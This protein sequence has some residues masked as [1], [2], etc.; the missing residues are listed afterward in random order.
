[1]GTLERQICNPEMQ[2]TLREYFGAEERDRRVLDLQPSET[3]ITLGRSGECTY[4]I[5]KTLGT[6]ALSISKVQA[7]ITAPDGV[8]LLQ[9]GGVGGVSANG[10][11]CHGER[12]DEPVPLVP[13]L[14]LTL[15]KHGLAKVAFSVNT[16][17]IAEHRGDTYT[18][19]GLVDVLQEQVHAISG[20]VA[21][22]N[23]QIGLLADQLAAR[24]ALDKQQAERDK[25][26]AERDKQQD[27]RLNRVLAGVC[28]VIAVI[29]LLS[30]WSGGSAE[31]KKA[32][33]STFTSVAI[34]IAALYFKSQDHPKP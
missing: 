19:Q 6:S 13:G 15:F 9:D 24:E 31:D 18:G 33:S 7:T 8:L 34:G 23:L 29:V 32:W 22:M 27:Q 3:P 14:E 4:Q 10:I 17:A 30:G 2:A 12:L 21:A 20:Q 11:Y 25:Q 16:T 5:G 1:M 26:Q 28:G